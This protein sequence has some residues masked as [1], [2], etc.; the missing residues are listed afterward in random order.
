MLHSTV[1]TARSIARP[2]QLTGFGKAQLFHLTSA[3]GRETTRMRSSSAGELAC[4][5]TLARPRSHKPDVG[6]Q[7]AVRRPT[8]WPTRSRGRATG[9][10]ARSSRA[11]AGAPACRLRT[12]TPSPR[13]A[14]SGGD[15]TR[16]GRTAPESER[17]RRARSRE[18]PRR[19][20]STSRCPRRARARAA[21]SPAAARVFTSLVHCGTA[22]R[23]RLTSQASVA[24]GQRCIRAH[25]NIDERIDAV[26]PSGRVG[27]SRRV[28]LRR[29]DPDAPRPP[30]HAQHAA[31]VHVVEQVC[32]RGRRA[33]PVVRDRAV[34]EMFVDLA[35]MHRLARAHEREH[36]LGS[37]PPHRN[38]RRGPRVHQRVNS[39][40]QESVV[41][42][43][44]LLDAE[45]RVATLEVARPIALHAVAQRQ[46]LRPRRGANRVSLN[47][48]KLVQRA[49]Q[50][51]R[52]EKAAGDGEGAKIL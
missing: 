17:P 23:S 28:H 24:R 50:R 22:K 16:R 18:A 30:R 38:G 31:V 1:T 26:A 14:R 36:L 19:P 27:G 3:R 15:P 47:E 4:E 29:V 9:A 40:R 52:W 12:G 48:P 7:L 20:A 13:A 10:A 34:R 41:D 2:G 11:C 21:L 5:R 8:C 6:P 46:V 35:R 25:G 45:L 32:G 51:R 49:F 33:A 42:E 43:E 37:L 39:A 44:V